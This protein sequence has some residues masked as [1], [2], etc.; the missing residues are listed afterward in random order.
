[1]VREIVDRIYRNALYPKLVSG[2]ALKDREIAHERALDLM[3]RWCEYNPLLLRLM[4]DF[5]TYQDPS[6]ETSALG[7]H[8]RSPLGIAAGLDKDARVYETLAAL[9]FDHIEVGTITYL[10]YEGNPRPRIYVHPD[11]R[12]IT[13]RMGFPGKGLRESINQFEAKGPHRKK[14]RYILGV[15]IGAS[16]PSFERGTVVEDYAEAYRIA[17]RYGDYVVANISSPNTEGVRGLQE[18]EV[19]G[20]LLSAIDEHRKIEIPFNREIPKRPFLIKLSPDLTMRQTDQVLDVASKHMVDGFVVT[21]TSTDPDLRRR[22]HGPHA[23]EPGGISGAPLTRKALDFSRHVFWATEGKKVIIRA[24]GI[25]NPQDYWDAI[26][27]G[28][29]DLVQVYTAF[30]HPATSTPNLAYDMNRALALQ[31]ERHG[32]TSVSELKGQY[33]SYVPFQR[34]F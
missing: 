7:L 21:N 15:N 13:N 6:L 3:E 26:S 11:D 9:G 20:E 19:L 25:M 31:M 28:G 4:D 22:L 30:V 17:R 29:A 23:Q 8:H 1:M 2:E 27:F 32:I 16:K 33:V 18:P 5:F 14:K 12:A 10:L 24:G 34:V